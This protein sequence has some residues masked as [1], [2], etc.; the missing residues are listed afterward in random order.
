[1]YKAQVRWM[2][3]AWW[4]E[5]RSRIGR[6]AR[7]CATKGPCT[8]AE[9]KRSVVEVKASNVGMRGPEWFS[10][11]SVASSNSGRM[12]ASLLKMGFLVSD[13]CGWPFTRSNE[14]KH[15]W[16]LIEVGIVEPCLTQPL[17]LSSPVHSLW[18]WPRKVLV[19]FMASLSA[20]I[21]SVWA[22]EIMV[23]NLGQIICELVPAETKL[24]LS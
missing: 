10:S 4:T 15:H 12:K 11:Q 8:S 9:P 3:S 13:H 20:M 23:P 1:M 16:V 2:D 17:S 14:P 22:A 6:K 18:R 19:W 21:G 7:G 5:D 24:M